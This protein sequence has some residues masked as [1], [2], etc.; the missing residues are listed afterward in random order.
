MTLSTIKKKGSN[1]VTRNLL[2]T[3]DGA[4]WICTNTGVDFYDPKRKIKIHYSNIRNG[5]NSIP[6][7]FPIIYQDGDKNLWLGHRGGLALLNKKKNLFEQFVLPSGN[8][9]NIVAEVRTIQQDYLGNLWVGTYNGVYI[10]NSNK[11][12]IV[13]GTLL[14]EQSI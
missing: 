10:M 11:S 3:S 2:K 14:R 9:L 6:I 8:V 7:E 5:A 4:L 13:H 12:S 1:D